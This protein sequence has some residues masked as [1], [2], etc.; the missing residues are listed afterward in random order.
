M[1]IQSNTSGLLSLTP[2]S[3]NI[4][5]AT[6]KTVQIFLQRFEDEIFTALL[7]KIATKE[8][9][10]LFIEHEPPKTQIIISLE[11]TITIGL[12]G[13]EENIFLPERNH[14]ICYSPVFNTQFEIKKGNLYSFI[15]IYIPEYYVQSLGDKYSVFKEFAVKVNKGQPATVTKFSSIAY[16]NSLQMIEVI[17]ADT[18]HTLDFK[19]AALIQS[20]T[21]DITQNPR[22]K[23]IPLSHIQIALIYEIKKYLSEQKGT[24]LVDLEKKFKLTRHNLNHLFETL[25]G[26]QAHDYIIEERMLV[27]VRLLLSNEN[28]KLPEIIQKIGYSKLDTLSK[29]FSTCFGI[30]PG[31][32]RSEHKI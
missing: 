3:H 29:N 9:D 30:P 15:I 28:L 14:T 19:I 4:S 26:I 10:M 17:K 1:K 23:K 25:I 13:I 32:Y 12:Q 20:L 22:R 21:K 8:N 16:I 27:V 5:Q 6:S 31:R 24:Q 2:T 11:N 18:K 7:F